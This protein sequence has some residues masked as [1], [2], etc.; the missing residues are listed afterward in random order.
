MILLIHRPEPDRA[1]HLLFLS[2]PVLW[3]AWPFLPLVR[4]KPGAEDECGL[5]YDRLT[6]PVEPKPNVTVY[7]ANLFTLPAT[8]PEF[9]TLPQEVYDSPEAAFDAGWRVD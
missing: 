1:R 4:R 8:E 9:L 2:K 7:L 3:P 5:L 6:P